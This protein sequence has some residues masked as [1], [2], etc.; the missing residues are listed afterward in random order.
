MQNCLLPETFGLTVAIQSVSTMSTF[1]LVM[2]L[3]PEAQRKAQE[4]IDRVIGTDRLPTLADRERL[5]YVS[6]VM[7]ECLR[8]HPIAPMGLPHEATADDV[9]EGYH[10]PK[11]AI[12]LSSQW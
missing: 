1:F 3:F 9:Y 11:G 7:S 5:P 2:S 10:I 4:E 6:A 8:F 12:V